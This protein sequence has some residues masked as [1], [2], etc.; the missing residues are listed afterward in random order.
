MRML[1]CLADRY[2]EFQ[3]LSGGEPRLVTE[4]GVRQA[5]DQL[6][7][8]EP[9]AG[10]RQ[11][12]VEHACD[13]GMIHHRERL[14][15]LLEPLNHGFGI[16][17]G[18]DQLERHVPLDGL[19]LPGDPDLAHTAVADLLLHGVT[20]GDEDAGRARRF[21]VGRRVGGGGGGCIFRARIVVE[22]GVSG[23]LLN[24]GIDGLSLGPVQN[25]PRLFVS[26]Q[27]SLD[28]GN[29]VG[30][31]FAGLLQKCGALVGR[32]GQSFLEQRFFVHG[33]CSGSA[34]DFFAKC[35]ISFLKSSLP[36][37]AS[38]SVSLAMCAASL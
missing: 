20:A 29:E 25:I 10:G 8:E 14:P 30:L 7:G 9:L 17:P 19:G 34:G 2:E 4:S 31:P 35:S 3:P 37:M 26:R 33:L 1:H 23:G 18:L 36:R 21:I 11:A 16:H 12:A 24:V 15:F 32:S 5:V 22:G 27:Q 6:H 38:R 13:I 28:R